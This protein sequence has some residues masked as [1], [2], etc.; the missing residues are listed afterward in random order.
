MLPLCVNTIK[1]SQIA[2]WV[3][4]IAD[5]VNAPLI[6]VLSESH[7]LIEPNVPVPDQP[8][9][10]VSHLD[11]SEARLLQL[12]GDSSELVS[13]AFVSENQSEGGSNPPNICRGGIIEFVIQGPFELKKSEMEK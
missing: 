9:A 8:E 4:I 6:N 10:R 5:A 13:Q 11:A 3:Q 12:P 1:S 2:S 7:V